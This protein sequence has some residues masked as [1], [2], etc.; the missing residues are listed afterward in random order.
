MGSTPARPTSSRSRPRCRRCS[1]S[2]GPRR[3]CS[4]RRASSGQTGERRSRRPGL[5][6]SGGGISRLVEAAGRGC[7]RGVSGPAL[8]TVRELAATAGGYALDGRLGPD[9]HADADAVVLAVPAGRRGPAAADRVPA[10]VGRAGGDRLRV[11]WRSSRSPSPGG[12]AGG[13]DRVRASWCRRSR[14]ARSRRSTFTHTPSGAG[15]ADG[16]G[17]AWRAAVPRSGG[18]AR[19]TCCS[20]RRRSWSH[21]SA[22][23]AAAVLGLAGAAWSSAPGA[24]LGRRAAAVRG[25]ATSTGSPARP[26]A[27][28]GRRRPGGLPAR[29]TTASASPPVSARREAAAEQAHSRH[30]AADR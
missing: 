1:R 22:R 29:R 15:S 21:S 25:R 30:L 19:S 27:V 10:A 23:G 17:R 8:A 12:L 6:R 9:P 2:C 7:G 11:A 26:R 14:A 20:A 16:T 18:T 3:A 13:A 5:R 4:R 28:V 24:P